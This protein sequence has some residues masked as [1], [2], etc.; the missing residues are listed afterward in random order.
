MR[1]KTVVPFIAGVVMTLAALAGLT[2]SSSVDVVQAQAERSPTKA[3]TDLD[4]YYP[5]T[6]DLDPDD[7]GKYEM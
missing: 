2:L 7:L 1:P 4:V 6:E 5:G 3:L